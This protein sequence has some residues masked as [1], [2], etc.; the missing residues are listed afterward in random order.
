MP[1]VSLSRNAVTSAMYLPV[2]VVETLNFS[3]R[4]SRTVD[5]DSGTQ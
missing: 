2:A 1:L 4:T 5:P 3:V